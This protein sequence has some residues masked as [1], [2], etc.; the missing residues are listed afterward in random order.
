MRVKL[1]K[2]MDLQKRVSGEVE[3]ELESLIVKGVAKSLAAH[4]WMNSK[5]NNHS[6][7]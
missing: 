1:E 7:L 6:I 4:P 5:F 2:L 3:V